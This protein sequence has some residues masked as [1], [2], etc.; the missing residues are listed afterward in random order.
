MLRRLLP[1]SLLPFL[2]FATPALA[3][4][5]GQDMLPELKADDPE[6]FDAMFVRAHA[7]P[8]PQGRFWKI[9][10]DG[11]APSHLFGTFHASEVVDQ[12]PDPVW[13]ALDNARV[14]VFEL[15]EEEQEAMNARMMSD[16]TFTMDLSAPPLLNELTDGQRRTLSAA[17]QARGLPVEAANQMRPWLLA[18]LLGFPACHLRAAAAGAKVLDNVMVERADAKGA[19]TEGLETYEGALAGFSGFDRDELIKVLVADDELMKREED[20]Y[21]TSALLYEAGETAAINE[22]SIWLAERQNLDF[23][24]RAFNESLMKN[25]LDGRN[26]NWMPALMQHLNGGNA[27]IGVGALHLPGE[28]GLIELLRAEGYKIT[29]LD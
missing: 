16:P 17:F 11:V 15:S 24:P 2:F 3:N 27:F 9:E 7:F 14:A 25:L 6:G 8:N 13:Q 1:L 23:A 22:F 21:R 10:R 20:V 5:I 29:R 12:V 18:S 28:A 26:R 19:A 4:C